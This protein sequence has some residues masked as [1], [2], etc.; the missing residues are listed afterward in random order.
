MLYTPI[1][2]FGYVLLLLDWIGRRQDRKANK[3]KAA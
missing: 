2:A 1:V 3:H